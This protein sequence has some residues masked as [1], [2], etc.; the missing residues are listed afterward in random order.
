MRRYAGTGLAMHLV[1]FAI[2]VASIGLVLGG[3]ISI[4]SGLPV[5]TPF[6]D[7]M[8]G[9]GLVMVVVAAA[10]TGGPMMKYLLVA[11]AVIGL[12]LFFKSAPHEIHV[13]SGLGFGIPHNG[14]TVIG[15]I[16]I[17]LSVVAVAVLTFAQGRKMAKDKIVPG[18]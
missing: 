17:T 8:Y 9:L 13:A 10:R 14:H 4:E 2:G 6:G 16:M 15:T 5:L 1:G 7:I 18:G 3:A 12:G 11:G